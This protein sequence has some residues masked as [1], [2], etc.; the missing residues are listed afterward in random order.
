MVIGGLVGMRMEQEV[1]KVQRLGYSS[2]GISLPKDWARAVGLSPGS[3][4]SVL[5]DGDAGLKLMVGAH[6]KTPE[7]P[8][9]IEAEAA[10]GQDGLIR[11]ITGAYIAGRGTIRIKSKT[12]LTA[13][14]LRE[15][16]EAVRGLSGLTIVAQ[17]PRFVQIENF[18][19]PS[20]FPIDGLLR[21][22]HYLTSRMGRLAFS[23]LE[24]AMEPGTEEIAKLEEEVDRI[25]WVLSRQ[26]LLAST[27]RGA[28]TRSGIERGQDIVSH[29]LM[30]LTLENVGDLW[31]EMSEAA[32]ILGPRAVKDLPQRLAAVRQDLE[33]QGEA[34]VTSVFSSNVKMA[35]E[36]LDLE[37][38]I[39][40]AVKALYMELPVG[41]PAR[42][43]QGCSSCLARRAVLR[44]LGQVAKLYGTL[45]HLTINRSLEPA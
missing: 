4:I 36:A 6:T 42:T 41:G 45:A 7:P 34:A 3:V 35:N 11:Q 13:A 9:E 39:V 25:Y 18:A 40:A 32:A 16:H 26:L 1:R 23:Q 8:C 19:E 38:T 28:A 21:R 14:Q 29:R 10:A 30:A 20:R 22:L 2:L 31:M 17:G 43:I 27:D 37:P 44:P 5:R 15:T 24:R 12:E 33:R